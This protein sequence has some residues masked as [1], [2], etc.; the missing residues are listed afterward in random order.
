[1][2]G[3][4]RRLYVGLFQGIESITEGWLLGLAA[5]ATFASVLLFYFWNSALTKIGSGFSGLFTPTIGAYG[6]IVPKA[7]E[8]AGYSADKIAFFPYKLI[9]FAGTYSEFLLPALIVVGLFTRAAALAMLGFI[10]VM[11]YVDINFHGVEA[12]TIGAF[13]DRVQ[14]SAIADQRLL[15]A[16]ILLVLVVKGAG[17]ISLDALL[18]R[19]FGGERS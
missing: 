16:F 8:E 6:Q 3:A 17:A 15:W 2:I 5:R 10:A 12:K 4:L 11:T 19:L 1:M 18:G 7:A 13:F 14:D 9:V